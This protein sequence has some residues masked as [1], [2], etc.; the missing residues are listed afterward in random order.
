MI[1]LNGRPLL[2]DDDL[3]IQSI[4]KHIGRVFGGAS[5][6]QGLLS[7]WD[8]NHQDLGDS[9]KYSGICFAYSAAAIGA[10]VVA[11]KVVGAESEAQPESTAKLQDLMKVRNENREGGTFTEIARQTNFGANQPG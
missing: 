9:L 7:L 3:R 5:L 4:C 11:S 6:A 2:P 10:S 8:A 1:E